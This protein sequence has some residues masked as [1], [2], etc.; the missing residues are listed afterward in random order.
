MAS[1]SASLPF[2]AP[3]AEPLG[4]QPG[5][6]PP[7]GQG[8]RVTSEPQFPAW[9]G[10]GGE[11][12]HHAQER[13]HNHFLLKNTGEPPPPRNLVPS[14]PIDLPP[15]VTWARL[16]RGLR[17]GEARDSGAWSHKAA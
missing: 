7:A 2:P 11:G 1:D 14:F 8:S 10:G 6:S 15:A 3:P 9:L 17:R 4:H 16:M 13:T 12:E 5:R